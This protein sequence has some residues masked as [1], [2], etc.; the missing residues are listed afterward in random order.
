MTSN[1]IAYQKAMVESRRQ[2]EDARHNLAQE[3]VIDSQIKSNY[4]TALKNQSEST[5]VASEKGTNE[6]INA[7][8][9]IIKGIG[10]IIPF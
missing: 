9:N 1:Q 6:F 8:A 10:S 2:E 4:A 3:R 7:M 5:Y